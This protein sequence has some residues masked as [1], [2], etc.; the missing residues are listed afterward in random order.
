MVVTNYGL[1]G[2]PVYFL[3]EPGVLKIDLKPDL[4]VDQILK[5][6]LAVK[7]NFSPFRRVKKQLKL[8]PAALALLFH[9]TPPHVLQDS[10]KLA[11]FLKQFPLVL[12]QPQSLDE[13]ISSAGGLHLNELNADFMLKKYPGVFA[14]GEMLNWDAPTGGFLIQACVSQGYAAGKGICKFLG[15]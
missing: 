7:E 8:S 5:K 15:S 3:G 12:T 4:S 2:T 1:E 10:K 14:A 6:C 9:F 11:E 13:S